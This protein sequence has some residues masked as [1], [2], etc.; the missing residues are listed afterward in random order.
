[1]FPRLLTFTATGRSTAHT[2][3]RNEVKDLERSAELCG[4]AVADNENEAGNNQEN[5]LAREI[6]APNSGSCTDVLFRLELCYKP[7]MSNIGTALRREHA[8]SVPLGAAKLLP[9]LKWAGGKRWQVPYLLPYWKDQ[10]HRRLV[11]PFCGGLAASFGLLPQRALLNDINPNLINFY[12]WLKNGL[13]IDLDMVN[14]E[15]RFYAGRG[16]FNELLTTGG[17]ETKEA[18]SLFY[19]LNRTCYNGLCRF[20]SKGEFNVPFGSYSKILYRRDF[21]AYKQL[22][23]NWEFTSVTFQTVRLRSTDFV[24]ADPPYDVEFRQYSKGGFSWKQQ[25]E[26]AA[27]LATHP[28]PVILSNQATKRILELYQDY[29]FTIVHLSGP[30][31]ISCT[32]DRS[33]AREVLALRNVSRYLVARHPRP[34]HGVS[35][36][37]IASKKLQN[38]RGVVDG[39]APPPNESAR[40]W[41]VHNGYEDYAALIDDV[42]AEW[43]TKGSKERKDWWLMMSGDS[44]GQPRTICNRVFPV[45]AAFQERQGKPVTE[46]AERRNPNEVTPKIQKQA[47]WAGRKR[48]KR[49]NHA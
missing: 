1:M 31:K 12:R 5:D 30:R 40:E 3:C 49:T 22:F 17:A 27:W 41:L 34:G 46:N 28:G 35:M 20:N 13:V 4:R 47:R 7:L 43:K 36:A 33:P 42:M 23:D 48:R 10:Q 15:R 8:L 24:Y 14:S 45:L 32:G 38:Q 19:Y 9:P 44:K 11:E 39:E 21:T 18:A 26:T 29:R 37:K 2:K 25:E 6:A 16:R